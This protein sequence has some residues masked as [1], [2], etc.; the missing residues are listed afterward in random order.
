M[1]EDTVLCQYCAGS[2]LGM[3][4]GSGNCQKCYGRGTEKIEEEDT[5]EG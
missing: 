3:H 5:Y 2:G 1:E 4:E